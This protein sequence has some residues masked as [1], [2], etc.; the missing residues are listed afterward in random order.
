V[1]GQI[2]IDGDW[3]GACIFYN[4]DAQL[5]QIEI[6]LSFISP[7]PGM[8]RF[9]GE[10]SN[11]S[12]QKTALVIGNQLSSTLRFSGSFRGHEIG[13]DD[14]Y[15]EFAGNVSDDGMVIRGSSR[16]QIRLDGN[17]KLVDGTWYVRR[18][19]QSMN[20]KIADAAKMYIP[21]QAAAI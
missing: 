14:N 6:E 10:M 8:G 13:H 2:N 19:G 3:A 12:D 15:A 17:I 11:I 1:I 4:D 9:I 5:P 16:I 7:N 21:N 20:Q 18:I